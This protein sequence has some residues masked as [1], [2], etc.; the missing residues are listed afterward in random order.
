MVDC[1]LPEVG[2]APEKLRIGHL[3]E[4]ETVILP[5]AAI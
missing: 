2:G 4:E 3:D 1:R 5:S